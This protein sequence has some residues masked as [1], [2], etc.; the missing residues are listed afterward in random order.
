MKGPIRIGVVSDTHSLLRPEAVERLG[1]VAHI[2]HAGDVGSPDV[3]TALQKVAP[4]TAV[5]GNNDSGPWARELPQTALLE[6]GGLSL[7]V[8]HDLHELDLDPRA[9]GIAAVI[10]GHSHKPEMMMRD[11]VLYFNPGSIG[12]RRFRLPI[13]MGVL[14]IEGGKVSGQLTALG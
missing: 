13:S 5:R 3:L 14:F 8:I 10:C 4:L 12:P 6:M 9:A 1:G 2:V 11:E 7:Y